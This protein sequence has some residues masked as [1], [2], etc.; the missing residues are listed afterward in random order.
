LEVFERLAADAGM[1]SADLDSEVHPRPYFCAD[2]KCFL[3]DMW[4]YQELGI[5]S[6]MESN[7]LVFQCCMELRRQACLVW[8]CTDRSGFPNTCT[9]SD[10]E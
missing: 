1:A 9:A 3:V 7:R 2:W 5:P 10:L 4:K 6:D 8:M